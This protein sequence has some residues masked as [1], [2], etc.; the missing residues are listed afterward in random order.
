MTNKAF[1]MIDCPELLCC[2]CILPHS[3]QKMSMDIRTWGC[4]GFW[5]CQAEFPGP[6]DTKM[7][8]SIQWKLLIDVEDQDRAADFRC[9]LTC[10]VATSCATK[11]PHVTRKA[12]FNGLVLNKRLSKTVYRTPPYK[13]EYSESVIVENHL[14]SSEE[15]VALDFSWQCSVWWRMMSQVH[16][17]SKFSPP[18][19]A[20]PHYFWVVYPTDCA[21]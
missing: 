15:I 6:H 12:V 13:Y 9:T 4:L 3:C 19:S 8:H 7:A 18:H 20:F 10:P 11:N 21:Q 17:V 14:Q 16:W 5:D 2:F 1:M